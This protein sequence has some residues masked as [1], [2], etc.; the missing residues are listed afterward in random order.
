[1]SLFK[2]WRRARER[3]HFIEAL[4]RAAAAPAD[5]SALVAAVG[6]KALVFAVS[7]GRAGTEML[8]RLFGELDDVTATHEPAPGFELAMRDCL[9]AP[10]LAR[11]FL[12][13]HKLPAIAATTASIYVET[14]HIF[15]KAFLPAMLDLGLRPRLI[16]TR[17]TPRLI[18]KSLERLDTIPHRSALGRIYLLSPGDPNLLPLLRWDDLSDYQ[19]CY[20]YAL[21]TERRQAALRRAAEARGCV[22]VDVDTN[23]LSRL[24]QFTDLF[25]GLR[26]GR[27]L[28]QAELTRLGSAVGVRHNVFANRPEKARPEGAPDFDAL[29]RDVL[30]RIHETTPDFRPST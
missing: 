15:A 29:E 26:L 21:E 3:R 6:R 19:L 30:A 25:D 11:A 8:C 28:S 22:C 16:M 14:S 7:S 9:G 20:W 18:A 1:M 12:V 17:R 24:E 2:S 5:A 27:A 4:H 10:E 13:G 23:D